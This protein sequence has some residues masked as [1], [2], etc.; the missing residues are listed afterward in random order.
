MTVNSGLGGESADD[1][2]V[3]SESVRRGGSL[4]TVRT[5]EANARQARSA[6]DGH[7][8]INPMERRA[9]YQKDGWTGFD[10]SAPDYTPT[11]ADRERMRGRYRT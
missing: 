2:E 8:P 4:V 6:L 11:D 1:A 10:Q 5:D 3:Y 9:A 7:G